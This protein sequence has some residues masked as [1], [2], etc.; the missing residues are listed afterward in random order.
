MR[1]LVPILILLILTP[2]AI[3]ASRS[4]NPYTSQ[5]LRDVK[6]NY[7]QLHPVY[8]RFKASYQRKDALAMADQYRREQIVCAKVDKVDQRDTIDPNTDLFAASAEL[9]NVCN[10]IE[11]A[12]AAWE[13]A[14]HL[15]WDKR[16]TPAFPGD[17]WS[18]EDLSLKKMRGYLR[19][20]SA[21][22]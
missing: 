3:A 21:L 14:H 20:P 10:L 16:V 11:S 2:L 13:K 7:A 1:F 9:D 18:G 8:L 15:K 6:Q 17:L 5:A 22:S 4:S 19:H 12:Y